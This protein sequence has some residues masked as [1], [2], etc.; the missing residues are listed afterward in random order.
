MVPALENIVFGA[1]I[2]TLVLALGI[3]AVQDFRKREVADGIW[4]AMAIVGG[5]VGF[6]P[7]AGL[8]SLATGLWALAAFLVLEHLF[9]WD[10]RLEEYSARLPFAVEAAMYG[11]VV[12]LVVLAGY[13]YGVGPSGV[14]LGVIAVMVSVFGV[15]ALFETGILYGGADAKALMVV[16]LVLPLDARTLWSPGTASALLAFYPFAVNALIDAA[17][18]SSA[19]PIFLALRNVARGEFAFPRGFLGYRLAV[20]E[21]PKRFVWLRDPVAGSVDP[22]TEDV[23]TSEEDRQLRERQATELR[24]RGLTRVW[25]T[26]QLPFVVWIL[27]GVLVSLVAGNLVFD[28]AASL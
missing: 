24:A 11:I 27:A 28:L 15:R 16:A 6:V 25:V 9:A 21:L 8:G 7:A 22:E 12:G 18:L 26:P 19:V 5:G 3:A 14:P 10:V 2:A 4:Q 13:R 17:L 23:A 20:D 1:R